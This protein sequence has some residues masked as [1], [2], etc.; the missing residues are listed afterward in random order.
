MN[1]SREQ[2]LA[3][4]EELVKRLQA[5]RN[6]LAR[7]LAADSEE[8]ALQ[9]ENMAVLQ[10]IHRLADEELRSIEKEIKARSDE[11]SP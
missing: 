7:G 3:R 10:E 9:L 8:Q 4:K 1:R 5:I 2:L 6:D 11:D